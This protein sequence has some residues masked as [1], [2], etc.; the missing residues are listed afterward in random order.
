MLERDEAKKIENLTDNLSFFVEYEKNTSITFEGDVIDVIDSLKQIDREISMLKLL[1]NK[2]KAILLRPITKEI[3]FEEYSNSDYWKDDNQG[4]IE[5]TE[6]VRKKFVDNSI[7]K[8]ENLL[9]RKEIIKGNSTASTYY[10]E[11]IPQVEKL[12]YRTKVIL[13]QE[14]GILDFLKK[15]EPFKNSTNLAKLIAELIS[16]KNDDVNAVYNSIRTDLSYVNQKKNPKSPYKNRQ[17]KIVNST[18]ASFSL[19]IIK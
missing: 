12:Q 11:E 2:L 16:G 13:L 6:S 14:L 8:F 19:P 10:N 15:K 18:L 1:I 5:F 17:I 9:E 3:G 4:C 7:I